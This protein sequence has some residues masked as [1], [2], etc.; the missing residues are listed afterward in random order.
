MP[1]LEHMFDSRGS[2]ATERRARLE[3][4]LGRLPPTR[5]DGERSVLGEDRLADQARPPLLGDAVPVLGALAP[6]LPDGL[7]RGETSSIRTRDH[8]TDHLTL[9]LL[10]GA[11]GAGGGLWAAAVGVPELGGLALTELLA[12]TERPDGL[13]RLVLVPEPGDRWAEVVTQLAAG[14]DLVLV[15]PPAAVP[16]GLVRRVDARLR[17][18]RASGVRHGAAL[19]VLG[20]WA[21][22]RQTIWAERTAWTGLYGSGPRAGTGHLTGGR[23]TVHVRGR[24]AGARDRAVDLLLPTA[25]GSIA[26]AET[27]AVDGAG[28]RNLTA[29]A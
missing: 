28:R 9:A 5:A 19:L 2:G 22:A 1:D 20:D 13:D 10:A 3:A 12:G 8:L 25:T 14:F 6:V 24:G 27:A 7:Q 16:A 18:G 29:V 26:P 23:A 4:V 11:L 15:R 17:Q 21:S